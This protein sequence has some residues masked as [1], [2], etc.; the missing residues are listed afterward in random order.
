MHQHKNTPQ[1]S[2]GFLIFRSELSVGGIY[3]I[4]RVTNWVSSVDRKWGRE[5][6]AMIGTVCGVCLQLYS[7]DII[8]APLPRCMSFC[9]VFRFVLLLHFILPSC[10]FH[11][12]TWPVG[13]THCFFFFC[14]TEKKRLSAPSKLY[15]LLLPSHSDPIC[16]YWLFRNAI[17]VSTAEEQTV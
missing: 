9:L 13:L 8:C 6:L 7:S 17:R 16:Q 15:W 4:R 2:V 14:L 5:I 3:V 1:G 10:L 11:P 12:L